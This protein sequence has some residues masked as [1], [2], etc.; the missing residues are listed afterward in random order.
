VAMAAAGIL[1]LALDFRQS[2]DAPYPAS[3]LDINLGVRWA[4]ANARRFRGTDQVGGFGSSSGGHQIVLTALRPRD[5]RYLQLSLFDHRD[6]D[7]RLRF[8]VDAHADAVA[9]SA[10]SIDI[11]DGASVCA[12]RRRVIT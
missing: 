11:S 12:W 7:A 1:I 3:I 6:L 5:E 4:K 10:G 9:R 2:Q 8:V